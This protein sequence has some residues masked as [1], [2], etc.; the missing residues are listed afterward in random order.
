MNGYVIEHII[1]C[2]DFLSMRF[3]KPNIS[4]VGGYL[5][6]RFLHI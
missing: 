4:C 2:L 1:H 6:S 3:Y 5:K